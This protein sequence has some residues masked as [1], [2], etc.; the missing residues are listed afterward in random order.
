MCI[1]YNTNYF[2]LILKDHIFP[3]ILWMESYCLHCSEQNINES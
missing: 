2:I 3:V 1:E